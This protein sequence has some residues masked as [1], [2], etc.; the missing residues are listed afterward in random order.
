MHQTPC[1][2]VNH[3][4]INELPFIHSLPFSPIRRPIFPVTRKNYATACGSTDRS[5]SRPLRKPECG[6]EMVQIPALAAALDSIPMLALTNNYFYFHKHNGKRAVSAFLFIDMMERPLSGIFSTF[7][8][9]QHNGRYLHF[10]PPRF[11]AAGAPVM[12]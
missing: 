6:D 7:V 11:F 12:N 9:Q 5:G 3:C 2:A 8:F 1:S 4:R 10:F